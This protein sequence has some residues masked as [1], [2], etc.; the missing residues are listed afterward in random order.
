MTQR[1]DNAHVSSNMAKLPWVALLR[2]NFV[3]FLKRFEKK[4]TKK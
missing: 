4:Y 3:G 2:K 1:L